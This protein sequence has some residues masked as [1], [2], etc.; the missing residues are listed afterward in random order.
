[1]NN[2]SNNNNIGHNINSSRFY[3]SS[4]IHAIDHVHKSDKFL[5]S[6]FIGID[7]QWYTGP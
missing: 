3:F 6:T 7:A 4:N 1:M 2:K 5:V